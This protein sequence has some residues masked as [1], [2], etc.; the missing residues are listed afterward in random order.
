M[1][2]LVGT[3]MTFY[4]G[5]N[6]SN[7]FYATLRASDGGAT[8]TFSAGIK[9]NDGE[10]VSVGSLQTTT[11]P[12]EPYNPG[13]PTT[14]TTPS[15]PSSPS[16]PDPA[17]YRITLS[18]SGT[19]SFS[20][21]LSG[22][23]PPPP[24][25]LNVTITNTGTQPTGE[26]KVE[27]GGAKPGS[28]QLSKTPIDNIA[29]V[30]AASVEPIMIDSIAKGDTAEFTVRPNTELDVGD[31]TAT[32][33]VSGGNN[34]SATFDVSFTVFAVVDGSLGTVADA[35]A[36]L[37]NAP[38]GGD[39]NPV[40]LSLSVNLSNAEG[41]W[42]ALMNELG[43]SGQDKYVAL[44]LSACEMSST[45]FNTGGNND[46]RSKVV[47]LILPDDAQ[48]INGT[49]GAFSKLKNVSGDCPISIPNTAFNG[50]TS[51][52]T[53][54]FPQATSI[55]GWAFQNCTSLTTA[56]FPAAWTDPEL[57]TCDPPVKTIGDDAF[58]GCV[59]LET[60]TFTNA[61]SIG[62][63]AFKDCAALTTTDFTAATSIGDRAFENCMSLIEA[64]F[65][66]ATSIGNNV[67]TGCEETLEEIWF[68]AL[69]G[70]DTNTFKGYTA[71]TEA[72]FASAESIQDN[73]F[74][75]CT[76]LAVADFP[77]ATSIGV[78]AFKGCMS[79]TVADFPNVGG[80]NPNAFDG[81][82]SLTTAA[83]PL[84]INIFANAFDG[85]IALT[86]ATFPAVIEIWPA[87]FNGCIAL[88][89]AYFPNAD[90]IQSNAFANTGG[91]D[92]TITLGD[93]VPT[94][95]RL[96]T[97]IFSGATA[98]K[99][100]TVLVPSTVSG[101]YDTTW[102]AAFKGGSGISLSMGTY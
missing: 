24:P 40:P 73:A 14:P 12:L 20:S 89:T 1:V 49:F 17:T 4:V 10:W 57:L 21:A 30:G 87:A 47:S 6:T 5:G 38:G 36:Y 83:F 98:G 23:S 72:H 92:L 102:Q 54:D 95:E 86:T 37:Q 50:L 45:V 33:T 26:L 93:T 34:I 43:A 11:P 19:Y 2:K 44:D 97:D 58:A 101:N 78:D 56:N 61:T 81:C 3:S 76:S 59:L 75:G 27:L 77:E 16:S 79:L 62:G 71:L 55:G 13:T 46:G 69:E 74:N 84:A 8:L 66:A 94:D 60:A 67:F 96:G 85:C 80:I 31:Y 51:L 64:N 32:V 39:N 15:S 63:E 100:V 52:T 48:T 42:E 18:E 29:A 25:Q 65:P 41:G 53:A 82:T 35:L 70:V 90:N 9:T 22:Y 7:Y 68:S 28:F 99:P 88:T 91:T